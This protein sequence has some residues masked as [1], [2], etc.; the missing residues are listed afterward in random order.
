MGVWEGVIA[1]TRSP[2]DV[3]YLGSLERQ[4]GASRNGRHL[5]R[6]SQYAFLLTT[7]PPCTTLNT[8]LRTSVSWRRTHETPLWHGPRLPDPGRVLC[9]FDPAG[10]AC[11][12]AEEVVEGAAEKRRS[13]Q[14]GL[15][16]GRGHG[17]A[18]PLS[19]GCLPPVCGPAACPARAARR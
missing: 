12:T 9:V 4:N 3:V 6:C 14:A 7:N 15:D 19:E 18:Q 1:C 2:R 8:P 11:R 16:P 5:S 13:R 10:T 17:P